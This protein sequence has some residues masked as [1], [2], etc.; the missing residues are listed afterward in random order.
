MVKIKLSKISYNEQELFVYSLRI[1]YPDSD[2]SGNDAAKYIKKEFKYS[3]IGRECSKNNKNHLQCIVLHPDSFSDKQLNTYRMYFK[4]TYSDTRHKQP[5]SFT[6][7]STPLGLLVYVQKD[8]EYTVNMPQELYTKLMAQAKAKRT[9][10]S[11]EIIRDCFLANRTRPYWAEA[12]VRSLL[13]AVSRKELLSMPR[14]QK[15]FLIGFQTGCISAATYMR[16]HY[17]DFPSECQFPM[18][19]S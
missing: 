6:R 9:K 18:Q 3:I 16:S 17:G 5:V 8:N 12:T 7:A 14:R 1:D 4:R 2:P 10:T 19:N 13:D 15:F 11:T